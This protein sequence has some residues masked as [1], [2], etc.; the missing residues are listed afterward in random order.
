MN[1]GKAIITILNADSDITAIIGNTTDGTLRCFPSAMRQNAQTATYPYVIYHIVNDVPLNT[2]NGK[3]TYDYVTV[4][5]SVFHD[6]YTT[7][8]LLVGYI[9][10]ALDYT[11]GTFNGVVVDKIFFQGASEAFDDTAGMNGIYMYN[12]DF[13]FNLNL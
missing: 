10:N 4:Q 9:Q 8:Q 11:S 6:N 1:V 13:Q 3:S 12:M 2:K 5:I 7:L